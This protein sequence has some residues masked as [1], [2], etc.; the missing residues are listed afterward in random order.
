MDYLAEGE[1]YPNGSHR[2]PYSAREIKYAALC[3]MLNPNAIGARLILA[4]YAFG[5]VIAGNDILRLAAVCE[6]IGRFSRGM[7]KYDRSNQRLLSFLHACYKRSLKD[8]WK[9]VGNEKKNPRIV[10]HEDG[11]TPL[12]EDVRILSILYEKAA[13]PA[14]KS[15]KLPLERV[16]TSGARVPVDFFRYR[17]S[18][19]ELE[20]ALSLL[21]EEGASMSGMARGPLPAAPAK[22]AAPD[23]EEFAQW[24][25][26]KAAKSKSLE[27]DLALF[28][29]H[30][31]DGVAFGDLLKEFGIGTPANMQDWQI[32]NG[33]YR[34]M[35]IAYAEFSASRDPS[36]PPAS[37]ADVPLKK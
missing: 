5:Q 34:K 24:Y 8:L 22:P 28:R 17:M 7:H 11:A 25:R 37:T 14:G 6:C 23:F 15:A 16:G 20:Y 26:R 4:E 33:I 18:R 9:L 21:A 10:A 12:V 36:S 31:Q 32:R 1:I 19:E 13:E 2:C 30:K 35:K 27:R 29:R 3:L